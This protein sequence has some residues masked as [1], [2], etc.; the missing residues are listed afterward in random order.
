MGRFQSPIPLFLIF[1]PMTRLLSISVALLLAWNVPAQDSLSNPGKDYYRLYEEGRLIPKR[2]IF[3][4]KDTIGWN[5]GETTTGQL[6]NKILDG[7]WFKYNPREHEG[8]R[9]TKEEA[10]N[11]RY[12]EIDAL[13]E[14][15]EREYETQS[16]RI[17]ASEGFLPPPPIDPNV[18]LKIWMIT[19]YREQNFKIGVDVVLHL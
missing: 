10:D 18:L 4:K 1:L 17:E 13:A 11:F 2:E 9:I 3:L 16:K 14:I 15:I 6:R 8:K 19:Q 12:S 5:P 7:K